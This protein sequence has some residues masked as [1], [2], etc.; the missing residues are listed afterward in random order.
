MDKELTDL[1]A[2][3]RDISDLAREYRSQVQLLSSELSDFRRREPL[4]QL[5]WHETI[6]LKCALE[7]AVAAGFSYDAGEPSSRYVDIA[8][9]RGIAEVN[10]LDVSRMLDSGPL[11]HPRHSSTRTHSRGQSKLR[12][13]EAGGGGAANA[14]LDEFLP[15]YAPQINTETPALAPSPAPSLP[16]PLASPPQPDA[17]P[18]PP[19]PDA[20]PAPSLS[21]SAPPLAP[22]PSFSPAL[23][24]P[25]KPVVHP[26]RKMK[27]L[28]WQR[29]IIGE[30]GKREGRPTLW[31]EVEEVG[32][33]IGG[34]GGGVGGDGQ[35]V[36]GEWEGELVQHFS[37]LRSSVKGG[38]GGAGAGG[39]AGEGAGGGK[40]REEAK[41]AD[42]KEVRVLSDKRF[43][44]VSIMMTSL[45]PI[46]SVL[47]A[48]ARLDSSIL[49]KDQVAALR[50]NLA[51]DAELGQLTATSPTTLLSRPDAFMRG[52]HSCE[53][54]A[55][56]LDCWHW[57]L[58]HG[59]LL[60]EVRLPLR[61]IDAAVKGVRGG[62]ELKRLLKLLLDVGNFVNGGTARGQADGFELTALSRLATLRDNSNTHS[63]LAW[64][65]Q[66]A[67]TQLGDGYLQRLED[68]LE[69][70]AAAAD[71]PLKAALSACAR[72]TS[73]TRT[74]QRT[75]TLVCAQAVRGDDPF[76]SV[77]AA[78]NADAEGKAGEVGGEAAEVQRGW[79]E[80][81]GW[82][83]PTES[84]GIGKGAMASEE[85]CGLLREL[86]LLVREVRVERREQAEEEAKQKRIEDARKVAAQLKARQA[87]L[88]SSDE[89]KHQLHVT[90][91]S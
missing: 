78:F 38:G 8:E 35:G 45:P 65:L 12:E 58:N 33:G 67:A 7:A 70:V 14:M 15:V 22:P 34:G 28:H 71:F 46:D 49:S 82:M 76:R 27:A 84:G 87:L 19:A 91:A 16:S 81:L 48:I 57:Q 66:R 21:P 36:G 32:V 40:P 13:E 18:H 50:R 1:R 24:L 42:T 5:L 30:G 43:N 4:V 64:T 73:L 9:V 63:L 29:L 25:T 56:R 31:S 72:F 74:M 23:V 6:Q 55:A 54:V 10:G 83:N 89:R 11:H 17:P 62:V 86:R 41:E 26:P 44:A 69:P 75:A 52:L 59:E 3:V 37:D 2:Q 85:L 61:V 88:G 60:E 51:D 90:A 39:K 79:V 53:E 77:F 68:E 20:P 80:L 47:A